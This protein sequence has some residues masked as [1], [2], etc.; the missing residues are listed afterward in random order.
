M[1][2]EQM[3]RGVHMIILWLLDMQNLWKDFKIG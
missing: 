1:I 3:G 2:L